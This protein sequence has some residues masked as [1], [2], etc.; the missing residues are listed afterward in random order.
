MV[1]TRPDEDPVNEEIQKEGGDRERG[2]TRGQGGRTRYRY[3]GGSTAQAGGKRAKTK[4][5]NRMVKGQN[6]GQG[7]GQGHASLP[8]GGPESHMIPLSPDAVRPL[9]HDLY[10][11]LYYDLDS[12]INNAV[13]DSPPDGAGATVN[14][15]STHL[16]LLLLT[17]LAVALNVP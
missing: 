13:Q 16:A 8:S 2:R 7:Q 5:R 15:G 10:D 9:G 6:R 1:V 11:D 12:R 14:T 4:Q 17:L 3:P